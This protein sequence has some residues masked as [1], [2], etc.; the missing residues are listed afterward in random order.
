VLVPAQP[1]LV[2][3]HDHR[4]TRVRRMPILG[5]FQAKKRQRSVDRQFHV[6]EVISTCAHLALGTHLPSHP[7]RGTPSPVPSTHTHTNVYNI[8]F[9]ICCILPVPGDPPGTNFPTG[10]GAC[11]LGTDG[12]LTLLL[13]RLLWQFIWVS[14][15]L[16]KILSATNLMRPR[17]DAGLADSAMVFYRLK[18]TAV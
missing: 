18:C 11:L 7:S 5:R 17:L 4:H 15:H 12:R 2:R 1:K 10:R 6:P 16:P 13:S 14:F 3:V 9:L 8:L